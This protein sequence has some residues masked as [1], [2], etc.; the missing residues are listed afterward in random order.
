MTKADLQI[1]YFAGPFLLMAI[2]RAGYVLN[3]QAMMGMV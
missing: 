3:Q 2:I 1:L